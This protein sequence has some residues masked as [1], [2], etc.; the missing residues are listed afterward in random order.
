MGE[1]ME[2]NNSSKDSK[3]DYQCLVKLSLENQL[4]NQLAQLK[5]GNQNE[6]CWFSPGEKYL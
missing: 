3:F 2:N 1:L 6:F 5:K 4:F